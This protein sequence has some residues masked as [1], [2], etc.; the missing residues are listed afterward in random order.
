MSNLNSTTALS[1]EHFVEGILVAIPTELKKAYKAD[2]SAE[3]AFEKKRGAF[4]DL[5]WSFG[6]RSEHMKSPK[7]GGVI[8][9]EAFQELND[10][11]VAEFPAQEQKLLGTPTASLDEETKKQKRDLQA[12]IG[13]KRSDLKG[14][15]ERRERNVAEGKGADDK[16]TR[17]PEEIINDNVADC[18]KRA[19][20]LEPD[21]TNLDIVA[22]VDA[23]K[24][25][26][27]ILV[28]TNLQ[29]ND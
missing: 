3:R 28:N 13:S 2:Q 17:T 7:T 1:S 23:L 27:K 9:P 4:I 12:K 26:Q 10:M 16:R 5:A 21:N 11:I 14:A 6:I 29:S 20:A 18:L 8:S 15:L 25:V 19:R 22:L 24:D